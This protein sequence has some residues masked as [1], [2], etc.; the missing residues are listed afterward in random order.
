MSKKTPVQADGSGTDKGAPDGV[1]QDRVNSRGGMGESGGGS[2]PNPHEGKDG[3]SDF[4]GFMGH[5]GQTHL[6][7][8]I[9]KEAGD[10][11]KENRG[12]KQAE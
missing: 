1:S 2:Y 9:A 8:R 5:G 11:E 7:E 3:D 12:R 6:E 10:G 4:G